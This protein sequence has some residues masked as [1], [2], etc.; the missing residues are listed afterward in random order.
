MP[1]RGTDVH[2]PALRSN[3]RIQVSLH[4]KRKRRVKL[5]G[6]EMRGIYMKHYRLIRA[7]LAAVFALSCCPLSAFADETP[8]LREET[9]IEAGE[10]PA[11]EDG[12]PDAPE[13]GQTNPDNPEDDPDAQEESPEG[14]EEDA[15][16][17]DL[18]EDGSGETGELPD[19]DGE[20]YYNEDGSGSDGDGDFYDDD[21][22]PDYGEEPEDWDDPDDED[23]PYGYYND[24]WYYDRT[25]YQDSRIQRMCGDNIT[26]RIVGETMYLIGSGAMWDMTDLEILNN[27]DI[28]YWDPSMY[29][30]T[31][32]VLDDRITEISPRAFSNCYS[33][34]EVVLP[35]SLISINESAFEFCYSIREIHFPEGLQEIG[36]HAFSNCGFFELEFPESLHTLGMNAFSYNTELR[37]VTMPKKMFSIGAE[38]FKGCL[39]LSDI[40][41]PEE[42]DSVGDGLF[43][44]C[45]RWFET[46]TDE[47]IV[48]GDGYLYK[49][50][51]ED[52]SVTVPD[53]VKH[54]C[55]NAFN[56]HSLDSSDRYFGY[57]GSSE[58]YVRNEIEEIVLP[59]TV[60]DIDEKAFSD[61]KGL[62]SVKLSAS[63]Q[64]IPYHAFARC[65]GLK[66]IVIPES[67]ERIGQEAFL[68]CEKLEDVTVPGN[69]T[70]IGK[71]AF[72]GTQFL[73]GLGDYAIMGDGML[74]AYSGKKHILQ[75]PEGIKTICPGAIN[76]DGI[77]EI[78]LPSSLR[79]VES[80]GIRGGSLVRI[81]LNEGLE[82][83]QRYGI[84][85][86]EM[87]RSITIPD[88]LHSVD[89]ES[90][91]ANGLKTI[92]GSEKSEAKKLAEK[93]D[94]KYETEM[95]AAAGEDMT[96]N[97]K[98]EVWAFGNSGEYFNNEYYLTE[99]DRILSDSII[100]QKTNK[101]PE[102]WNGDCF[103][104]ALSVILAKNGLVPCSELQ[105]DAKNLKDLEPTRAVQSMINY[106]H[107]VQY[108]DEYIRA[109]LSE[110]KAQRFYRM[111]KTAE[112]I[113]NGESPFLL[114]FQTDEFAHAVVGY[115]LEHGE[116][117]IEDKTYENRILVWDPNFPTKLVEDTCLYYNADTF[118]YCIPHYDVYV[119]NLQGS[120]GI[121]QVV[122]DM[123][124]LNAHPYPFDE[125]NDVTEITGTTTVEEQNEYP[126]GDVNGNGKVDVADA[127]LLAR[128]AAEDKEVQ[129]TSD[130]AERADLNEDSFLTIDDC[131]LLLRMLVHLA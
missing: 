123:A 131:T 54:I 98:D 34:E 113:P 79:K 8:E 96:L 80:E 94:V 82:T 114:S 88:S 106:Y 116:W 27:Q 72:K 85:C 102:E 40:T 9:Y 53:T 70:S 31:K 43:D 18:Q 11:E 6:C 29:Y 130:M 73:S 19:D 112:E 39:N 67:V 64:E 46:Q 100:R 61:M 14:Q 76:S 22:K 63:L 74:I 68:Y 129:C 97:V 2:A 25:R 103:G 56:D 12:N 28:Y 42:L 50:V 26:W 105:S 52:T 91:R 16:E 83:V 120:T 81:N 59:D 10:Y 58:N 62:K 119:T 65:I 1:V 51:G 23:D 89:S 118:D 128:I 41:L 5:F 44:G 48:L 90:I 115:G 92:Y 55:A 122:N 36:E 111:I 45:S 95:Q 77:V 99:R 117:T 125:P 108:S 121:L 69:V 15:G 60:L 30:V 4:I 7:A 75:L 17:P 24:D 3:A 126:V 127:V 107:T 20:I 13:D 109:N 101:L 104:L 110:S 33:V 38:C 21:E 32:I 37:K 49:Y 35:E 78:T 71:N 87:C 86:S 124:V 47:F 57:Y 93:R 66:S 84:V